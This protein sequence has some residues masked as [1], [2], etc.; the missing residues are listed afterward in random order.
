MIARA[1]RRT[2]AFIGSAGFATVVLVI[3]GA[4]SALATAV[5][6]GAASATVVADWASTHAAIE[7]V[8]S[9]FGLHQAFSSPLFLA[10]VAALAVST[11]LCAWQRTKVALHRAT[12][13]RDAARI[14]SQALV[15]VHDLEV[16]CSP[17]LSPSA[18]LSIASQTLG[19]LGVKTKPRDGT[20][21]AVSGGWTVWGSAVFHWALLGLV[22]A[23][24]VGN[25]LRSEGLMGVVV[26]QTK[27]DVRESYGKLQTGPLHDWV[28]VDRSIR[29][30]DF[31]LSYTTGGVDRGPTP[32]VSLLDGSGN[33][34]AS[35]RVYPNMTLKSG[36][37]T[38]Y[39]SSYGLATVVS[40]VDASGT[41]AGRGYQMV[42]FSAQAPEGTVAAGSIA[43]LDASG[44]QV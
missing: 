5:P 15:E 16:A 28:A 17:A 1:W 43:V 33:V 23:L 12:L 13:L 30:D 24:L 44:T 20:L 14:D 25:M 31:E 35:Q 27:P 41:V 22:L 40:E 26:G 42:D 21:V 4:W 6:Q 29:V 34:I 32:T 36:S 8:V 7:P 37:V 3:I 19:H 10:L 11:A 2:I 38:V 9:A 39:P 18:V